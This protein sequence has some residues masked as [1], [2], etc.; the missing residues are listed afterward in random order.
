L[1]AGGAEL[2]DVRNVAGPTSGSV[3]RCE[4]N[5]ADLA[6]NQTQSQDSDRRISAGLFGPFRPH[7]ERVE[8][9]AGPRA[10]AALTAVFAGSDHAAVAA[11]RQAEA[12]VGASDQALSE[13]D[14]LPALPRRKII[15]VYAAIMRP[16]AVS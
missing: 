13:F 15:S 12:D 6:Q 10:I 3:K 1:H 8:R 5:T 16:R 11:L 7:V 14:K 4:I 2:G 9:V